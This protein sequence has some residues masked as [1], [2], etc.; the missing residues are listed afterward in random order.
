MSFKKY[1]RSQDLVILVLLLLAVAFILKIR[2]TDGSER[3]SN[4]VAFHL[5]KHSLFLACRGVDGM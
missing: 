3:S 5:Q 4:V 2:G 1:E